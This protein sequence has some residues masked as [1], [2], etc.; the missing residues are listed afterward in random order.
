M[1][2]PTLAVTAR[3]TVRPAHRFSRSHSAS[4]ASSSPSPSLSPSPSPSAAHRLGSAAAAPGLLP[5]RATPSSSSPNSSPS[6]PTFDVPSFNLDLDLSL[7]VRNDAHEASSPN[8]SPTPAPTHQQP[9]APRPRPDVM[10]GARRKS[11][12]RRPHS[13]MPGSKSTLDLAL[14]DAENAPEPPSGGTGAGAGTVD[15]G[16][17]DRSRTL[18]DSFASFAR[19]SWITSSR[20]PSPSPKKEIGETT[21]S[22]SQQLQPQQEQPQQE[23]PQ[24]QPQ[25][26]QQQTPQPR[27]QQ[28]R[29]EPEPLSQPQPQP[30]TTSGSAV[31]RSK[32]QRKRTVST[33]D[34]EG[35]KPA[36]PMGKIGSYFSRIKQR[37]QTILAKGATVRDG[38][39]T[40]SSVVSLAP[41]ST[42]NTRLS[43]ATSDTSNTTAPDENQRPALTPQA[44][45]PLWS[46]FRALDSE[47]TK[48]QAKSVHSKIGAVRS[49]LIP[50]LRKYMSHPSNHTVSTEDVERRATIL[51]KWWVGIIDVLDGNDVPG[52]DR[53]NLLDTVTALMM[54][55]EWR[56]CTPQ[57]CPLTERNPRERVRR[58]KKARDGPVAVAA[59]SDAS[60]T[61]A[62]SDYLAES[63]EHNVRTMF[64]NNL[65]AQM[66]LVVNKLSQRHAPLGLVGF[67]ARACAYAFFFAPGVAEVLV[68]LWGLVPDLLRRTADEL[69]LPRRSR[70]ES[71]DMVALFPP[72]LESLGWTSVRA[73]SKTLRQ[74]AKLPLAV[75]KIPWHEGRWVAK[76]RGR[77]TDLFFLFCKHYH[78]LAAEFT[79]ADIPLVEKARAPAFVLV[80]AQTLANLDSTIHRQAAADAGLGPPISDAAHGVDAS[81]MALPVAPNNSNAHRGMGENR[82]LVLL[83]DVLSPGSVTSAGAR[84]AFAEAF[85]ATM[86]AAAKRT[87]QFDHN[88]CFTLCDFLEVALVAYNDHLVAMR[89]MPHWVD[90]T[91]WI[92]VCKR[93]LNSHNTM[94]EIRVLSLVFT[95]W[96]AVAGDQG[97]RDALCTGWLLTEETFSKLFNNWCPMV[98]AYYMRLLCWRICR[99]SGN[100]TELGAYVLTRP[101]PPGRMLTTD[102]TAKHSS[103]PPHV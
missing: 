40:S 3:P 100:T 94:S 39:S 56:Q 7:S 87:S 6:L 95:I 59:A 85:M 4:S 68:R 70:A 92:D 45:D 96:D 89:P 24:P 57:F 17:L 21:G 18:S 54:R 102:K 81:A 49:T 66:A 12:L 29:P 34:G 20:S 46:A 23:Q 26:P 78:T 27:P 88:A 1:S 86:K 61:S 65:V 43:N 64:V 76:W 5:S 22:T 62:D 36:E 2:G 60:L 93:I 42:T 10:A 90:W 14:M 77:E 58:P 69:W 31:K 9:E 79:P 19:R 35:A 8:D 83:K 91:F 80:Q 75:A 11:L 32:L 55:P 50:F 48:L 98:R 73:M 72:N 82:L 16:V 30:E 13:W 15:Q 71:E 47:S 28:S 41:P 101:M 37:P 33:V 84:Q 44:R 103:S 99:D 74:A 25:Q 53:P 51:N 67:A 38:D 63:A 52:V 97:R